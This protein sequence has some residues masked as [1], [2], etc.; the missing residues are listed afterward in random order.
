MGK[1]SKELDILVFRLINESKGAFLTMAIEIYLKKKIR[2]RHW[3]VQNFWKSGNSSKFPIP[4]YFF[5]Q[6]KNMGTWK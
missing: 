2:K 6:L 3:P 1:Y 4:V 5:F